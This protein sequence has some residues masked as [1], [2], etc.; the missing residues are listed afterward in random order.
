MI[1]VMIAPNDWLTKARRESRRL[2]IAA[3]LSDE[4]IDRL[5]DEA[6][7]EVRAPWM[8]IVVDTNVIVSAAIKANSLPFIVVDW[9]DRHACLLKSAA[10]EGSS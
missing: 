10:T 3:G 7:T 9:I 4:D 5:I 1:T 8:R 2:M 6:R